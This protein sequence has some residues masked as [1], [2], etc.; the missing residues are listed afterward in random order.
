VRMNASR[1]DEDHGGH[2]HHPEP[3]PPPKPVPIRL[4]GHGSRSVAGGGRP[5]VP[6][7]YYWSGVLGNLLRGVPYVPPSGGF[8]VG[9]FNGHPTPGYTPQNPTGV[10]LDV[11]SYGG[12]ARAPVMLTAPGAG[13]ISNSVPVSFPVVTP[14]SVGD[15]WNG[16]VEWG[17]FEGPG[18]DA[19]LLYYDI[20]GRDTV[21]G[22]TLAGGPTGGTF[23]LFGNFTSTP[24]PYNA[25]ALAV[26]AA[27]WRSFGA[28][29]EDSVRVSGPN[30]PAGPLVI[31]YT[32]ALARLPFLSL[33]ADTTGLTG[34]SSP[35]AVDTTLVAGILSVNAFAVGTVPVLPIGAV[36][37]TEA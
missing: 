2:R 3:G 22:L 11:D 32:D 23:T 17:L 31:Q 15:G 14:N 8:W 5:A 21:R 27:Y 16:V 20:L 9:L 29:Y 24:I 26:E 10:E 4:S 13:G 19:N 37:I 36:T 25:S 33:G 28:N 7:T 35:H 1:D 30:L 18:P 12:Y 6:K 34:G